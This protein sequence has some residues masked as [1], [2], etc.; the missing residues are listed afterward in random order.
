MQNNAA[1]SVAAAA[2]FK[3]FNQVGQW[4]ACFPAGELRDELVSS[5]TVNWAQRDLPSTLNW[6]DKSLGG[7]YQGVEEE[8]ARKWLLHDR[9]AA[10]A[11]I[12]GSSLPTTVKSRLIGP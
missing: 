7:A 2:M 1:K 11:W 4:V 3:D 12:L 5:I 8:L 10:S 6:V 9:T